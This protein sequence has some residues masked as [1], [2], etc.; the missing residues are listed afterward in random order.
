MRGMG[1]IMKSETMNSFCSQLTQKLGERY[2]ITWDTDKKGVV[3]GWCKLRDAVDIVTV[4]RLVAALKG[5]VMTISTLVA[6]SNKETEHVVINYHLFF[7]GLNCTVTVT[8]PGNSRKIAS[9][10]PILKSADWHEREMQEL[11]NIQVEG[12]PNPKK[13]FLDESIKM[14]DHTMIPLSEAMS[15]AST[16]TLWEKIMESKR[17][18]GEADE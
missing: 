1:I 5:R 3:C 16:S 2:E 4:A 7:E 13:L 8:L 10:T 14:T 6:D 9:I 17:Q 15:G 11:F 18:G 12:H